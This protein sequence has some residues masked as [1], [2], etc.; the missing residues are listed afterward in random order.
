VTQQGGATVTL[1]GSNTYS[2]QTNIDSGSTLIVGNGSTSG[3]ITSS[4]ISVSEPSPS[5][6][7]TR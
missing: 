4:L 3:S 6:A 2:G 7:Q 1:T 5:I